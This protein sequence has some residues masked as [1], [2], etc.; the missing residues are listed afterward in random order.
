MT[1]AKHLQA[2][3]SNACKA[4]KVCTGSSLDG[5]EARARVGGPQHF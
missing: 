5:G 3:D 4:L 2:C 1:V